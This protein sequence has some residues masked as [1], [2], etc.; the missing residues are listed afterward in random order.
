M[1]PIKQ[2]TKKKVY[3]NFCHFCLIAEWSLYVQIAFKV[4]DNVSVN[5]LSSGLLGSHDQAYQ[6][7][8]TKTMTHI[9]EYLVESLLRA[10]L[11]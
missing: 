4:A 10:A 7:G 9:N 11:Y 6:A 5:A 2:I 8:T 1:Q 3:L